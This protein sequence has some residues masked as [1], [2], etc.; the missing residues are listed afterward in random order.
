MNLKKHLVNY[1][2]LM[3]VLFQAQGL[4]AQSLKSL[5]AV[6]DKHIGNLMRDGFFNDHQIYNGAI[7]SIAKTEYNT[8][9]AGNKMKMSALLKNRPVDPFN[10]QISDINT[11]NIDKFVAYADLHGM[12]KRG[13]VMIWYKQI[14]T[15]LQNEAP[16]WTAQQIYDFSKSYILALS[17][18]TAGKIDEWDVLNE[19]VLTAGYRTNTWYD[20]VNSQATTTGDI[21][22]ITYFSNLFKWARQGDATVP[23]FYND[24]NIEPFGTKKK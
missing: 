10:V 17:T 11:A 22:Y 15:W 24:Y 16:T 23:L 9:V 1:G 18:Y 21:G 2:I 5:A 20:I 14:P 6:N 13:H 8:L 12:R 4:A 3:F 7:D 19:A